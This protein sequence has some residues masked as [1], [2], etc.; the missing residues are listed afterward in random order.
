MQFREITRE[1]RRV[2]R[3]KSDEFIPETKREIEARLLR[4]G[5]ILGVTRLALHCELDWISG[6]Q[7][8]D[9][10]FSPTFGFHAIWIGHRGESE[11]LE[12]YNCF[13]TESSTAEISVIC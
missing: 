12:T 8:V 1:A 7:I 3:L 2:N 13:I 10:D 11:R 6:G 5:I 9:I 4:C